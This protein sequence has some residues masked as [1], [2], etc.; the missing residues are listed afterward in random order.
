MYDFDKVVNRRGTNS[1]KYDFTA[2]RGKP[3]DILPLWVADMDFQ[4]A[5]EITAGLQAAVDHGIYGYSDAKEAYFQAVAQWMKKHHGWEV[6]PDWLVKTPGVVFAIAMAVRAFTQEGDSVLIQSPV[7]YPFRQTIERNHR[8]CVD[9]TLTEKNHHY[10]MNLQDLEQKIV[11]NRV[12]LFILCSPHNPVGRV[13]SRE[14]LLAVSEI[15]LKHHVIIVCDEIHHDFVYPGYTHTVLADLSKQVREITV[16]CTAP[17]KTFNLAGLQV[18]NIFISNEG[19]RE[20]FVKE[21]GKTGYCELNKMGLIACECAYRGG[22]QWLQE[23]REYLNGNLAFVR[24]FLQERLPK[25]HL[26]EP[27]GTYLLWLDCR[28][29]G[30]KEKEL[31]ELI[32]QKAGL[33]LDA[34]TMFGPTGA[35]FE[36]VNITCPRSVLQKGLEQLEKACAASG[37]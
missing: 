22:E 11:E 14:E 3:A 4:V 19:L 27:E 18:S 34:G 31:E 23:L 35:G 8:I 20:K 24:S 37:L 2:E 21:I 7:Y 10:E 15:C 9:N 25:I 12:K 16:T 17:S 28:E 1:L 30:L 5:Q 32:V 6:Q 29:L 33:W 26:V 36:R 13:W